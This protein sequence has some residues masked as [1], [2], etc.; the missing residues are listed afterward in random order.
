MKPTLQLC[1]GAPTDLLQNTKF[2]FSH[3]LLERDRS[4][5][6]V[7]SEDTAAPT[8]RRRPTQAT[9]ILNTDSYHNTLYPTQ[10]RTWK[11]IKLHELSAW[12]INGFIIYPQTSNNHLSFK[13]NIKICHQKMNWLGTKKPAPEPDYIRFL[14]G[15]V[16]RRTSLLSPLLPA[17]ST[18]AI[19]QFSGASGGVPVFN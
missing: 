3:D 4:V 15:C 9:R 19:P 10:H 8:A 1:P 14:T 2:P 11:T 7:G 5:P 16:L 13:T 12:Q 18:M 17:A 6:I